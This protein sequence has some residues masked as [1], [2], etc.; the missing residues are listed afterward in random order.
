M[1]VFGGCCLIDVVTP[2]VSSSRAVAAALAAVADA[3]VH[4]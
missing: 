1:N 2:L 3:V 4:Q